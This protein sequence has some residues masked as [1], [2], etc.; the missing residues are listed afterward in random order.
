MTDIHP[1]SQAI[2]FLSYM[3]FM[4]NMLVGYG[5]EWSSANVFADGVGCCSMEQGLQT[6]TIRFDGRY[7]LPLLLRSISHII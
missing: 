4:D 2:T 7:R 6:V 1:S 5:S 3:S